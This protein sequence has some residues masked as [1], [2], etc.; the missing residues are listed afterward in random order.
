MKKA[1][2]GFNRWQPKT[3]APKTRAPEPK[4][5]AGSWWLCTPETFY[6]EA[7]KRHVAQLQQESRICYARKESE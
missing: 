6:A 3:T 5:P 2:T 1:R 4:A 7:S